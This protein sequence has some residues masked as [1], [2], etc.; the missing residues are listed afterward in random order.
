MVRGYI[1]HVYLLLCL[2]ATPYCYVGII[3]KHSCVYLFAKAQIRFVQK[4]HS[5]AAEC[6]VNNP[7]LFIP[8][9]MV[10][11]CYQAIAQESA[12]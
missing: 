8:L 4:S 11:R 1:H 10:P 6:G 9:I 2:C 5:Q 7:P 12:T 3:K